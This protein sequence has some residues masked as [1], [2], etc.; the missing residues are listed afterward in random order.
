M[1]CHPRREIRPITHALDNAGHERRA[2]ELAH[3]ARHTNVLVYQRLV[4]VNHVLFGGFR[5][6]GFLEAVGLSAEEVLP[7]VL[8]DEV[9][10]GDDC[11]GTELGSW[12]FAVEEEIEEFEADGMALEIEPVGKE[13]TFVSWPCTISS[14]S[15]SWN[16]SS[17]VLTFARVLECP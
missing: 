13:E 5:V 7:D 3:L 15:C 6:G 4:V 9:E 8:L 12:W 11:K 1:R 10:E 2:V 14:M 16:L 17:W